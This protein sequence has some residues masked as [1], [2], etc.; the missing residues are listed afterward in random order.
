MD[1]LRDR[2]GL[3]QEIVSMQSGTGVNVRRARVCG[4]Q[5]VSQLLQEERDAMIDLGFTG[6]RNQPRRHLCPAAT[7]D[8]VAIQ[9]DEFRQS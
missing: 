6:R 4:P 5:Q 2:K 3:P 8:L 7:D 1:D 9:R